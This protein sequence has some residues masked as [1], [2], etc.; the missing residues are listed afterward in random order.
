MTFSSIL[1]CA[2][3]VSP[4]FAW[5]PIGG[6]TSAR[7]PT[8]RSRSSTQLSMARTPLLEEWKVLKNGQV[9]GIVKGHPDPDLA[10]G[11]TITQVHWQ[12]RTRQ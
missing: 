8:S 9:T 2:L 3:L 1:V 4:S 7:M 12:I 6:V 10:D 11:D 5:A